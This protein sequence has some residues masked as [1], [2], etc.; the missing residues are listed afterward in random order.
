[1][2]NASAPYLAYAPSFPAPLPSDLRPWYW[3]DRAEVI[4][5]LSDKALSLL[6]PVVAY[7]SL[8][9]FFEAVDRAGWDCFE[10]HRIHEPEEI[11]SKNKVTAREVFLA[12]V[13]QHV[14]QTIAGW[15]LIP[16]EPP[17]DDVAGLTWWG[18]QVAW[19]VFALGGQKKGA[20]FMAQYGELATRW[21]YW[22]AI[23][24]VRLAVAA[25]VMDGWQYMMHRT[26]H[27]V[28]WLYREIHSWHHRLYVPYAFGALYNHPLEGFV[29]D[30]VGSGI[31]HE[32][33]GLT[34]RQAALFFALS[35]FKTVDDHCGFA[36]PWD[37]MQH[38]F[39]NNADYHDIHHQVAGL[40]KNYSQPWFISW[41]IFFNTRMTRQEFS[42]KLAKRFEDGEVPLS[43][44]NGPNEL[45]APP[46]SELD[47]KALKEKVN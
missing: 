27:Q 42:T 44:V 16:E 47:G 2:F 34:L 41:D 21:L 31:A 32:V 45:A 12:V 24:A 33:A 23:P 10:R 28:T 38:L 40:K 5:G 29:L 8:S 39:G 15:F 1:M 19:A 9:L 6:A 43:R 17:R 36:F 13:F 25:A 30:T 14:V 7:W 3:A 11:K 46:T 22:Y 20:A 4:P 26:A 37:P 18:R 35:S